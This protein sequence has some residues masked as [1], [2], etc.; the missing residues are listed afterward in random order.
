MAAILDTD[1]TILVRLD[2]CQREQPADNTCRPIFKPVAE[3]GTHFTPFNVPDRQPQIQQLPSSPLLLFQT[4]IPIDLV[5]RWVRY[6]NEGPAPEGPFL[7]HSRNEQW[8]ETSVAEV[9]LWLAT[10]IY[11]GIHKESRFEDYW[12]T[13]TLERLHP[14]HPISQF[15]TYNRWLQLQRRIRIYDTENTTPKTPYD[16]VDEWS[17]RIQQASTEYY[18]PGTSIAVDECIVS[19][20][21]RSYQTVTV[22]NKPTPTGF[23]VW[24]VAQAGYFLY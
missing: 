17:Q 2:H 4:F 20:T 1:P 9:Y 24:V 10:L 23:K 8:R 5:K 19:Y 7:Q 22:P 3:K 14:K 12:K 6:T 16:R 13:S 18:N 11:M 21:G 15:L